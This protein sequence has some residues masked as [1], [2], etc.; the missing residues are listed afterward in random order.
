MPSRAKSESEV[1]LQAQLAAGGWVCQR[2]SNHA[3]YKRDVIM[4]ET[5]TFVCAMTPSDRKSGKNAL[6]QLRRLDANVIAVGEGEVQQSN[7][8]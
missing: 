4:S 6:S 3:V 1:A 8:L 5:Q 2:S 7:K